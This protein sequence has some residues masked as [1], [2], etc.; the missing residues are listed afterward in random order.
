[1][2]NLI[3]KRIDEYRIDA[4]LGQGEMG[5]VYRAYD[6]NLDIP[7]A[8]KVMKRDLASSLEFQ[9]RFLQEAR[10]AAKLNHPSIVNVI[11]FASRYGLLYIVMRY[12]PG[13]TLG[14]Y[15]RQLRQQNKRILLQETLYIVPQIAAALGYAQRNVSVFVKHDF[16]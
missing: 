7:A 2:D 9:R 10:A 4:Q 11:A 15:V 14:Q 5:T 6:V 8:L 1:M 12:V 16:D 3:R 13:Q